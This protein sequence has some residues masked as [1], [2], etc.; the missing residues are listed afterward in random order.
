MK[1]IIDIPDVIKY[2]YETD[3]FK[4]FLKGALWIWDVA[5][6]FMKK[7]QLRH[8]KKHSKKAQLYNNICKENG[9]ENY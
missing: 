2:D 7:K 8:L 5:V 6:A 3:K 1:V 4:D 9:Y